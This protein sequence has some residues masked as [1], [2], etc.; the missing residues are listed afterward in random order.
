[1]RILTVDDDL[2]IRELLQGVLEEHGHEVVVANDAEQA[3]DLLH[4]HEFQVVI[5]DWQ[6]PGITGIELCRRVR[7]LTTVGYVYFILLTSRDEAGSR[8]E[9]FDAGVDDYIPKPFEPG[10][11]LGRLRVADRVL[12]LE[13]RDVTI[14]ALAKLAE[15][16]DPETGA[17]IERVSEYSA[18][19][20]EELRQRGQHPEVDASFV[21]LIR[22]TAALHDIGKVAIPDAVLLKPG[23]LTPAEFAIMKTHASIGEQTLR[24]AAAKRPNVKFLTIAADIAAAHHEKWNGSGYPN[25]LAAES[26]PLAGRI[27]AVADVYD[28]LTSARPYKPAFSHE[29]SK[30]II[31]A[32]CGTHFDPEVVDAFLAIERQFIQ[33][34]HEYA[35]HTGIAASIAA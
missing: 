2:I 24:A 10:E 27:V 13:S 16:R 11:L 29:K 12:S 22:E 9:G 28:A 7:K 4:R 25:G 14:F 21:R 31:Q 30:A 15:S 17:H 8:V 6:M 18:A 23:K 5:S 1:M 20:A 26:I 3:L 19:L 34:A 32:D 35:D 33:I